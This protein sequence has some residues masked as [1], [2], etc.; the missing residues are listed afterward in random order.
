MPKDTFKNSNLS[1]SEHIYQ[2]LL[3]VP[4][5]KITTYSALAAAANSRAVRA[6]GSAMR[7]NPYPIIV[8]CHRVI[9]SNGQIGDYALG[10]KAIKA[11][12]L[13]LEGIEVVDGQVQNLAAVLFDFS[14]R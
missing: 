3:D 11:K 4:K 12:L 8:P 2:L 13:Q 6:V 9:K 10:G 14:N 1:F 7:K 5:G